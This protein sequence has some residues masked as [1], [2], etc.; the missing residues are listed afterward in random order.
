[1]LG[2]VVFPAD[3]EQEV[4]PDMPL[5][6]VSP[7][8]DL[9][10]Y[11]SG[12]VSFANFAGKC[13]DALSSPF[14]SASTIS[15]RVEPLDLSILE[16]LQRFDRSA[17]DPFA[18]LNPPETTGRNVTKEQR[19]I[20][21]TVGAKERIRED[22]YAEHLQM[23]LDLRLLLRRSQMISLTFDERVGY[24]CGEL[25]SSIVDEIH[26]ASLQPQWSSSYY[27]RYHAPPILF[28]SVLV[29][30]TI[31]IRTALPSSLQANLASYR[32]RFQQATT[33]IQDMANDFP[34]AWRLH[35]QLAEVIRLTKLT[36]PGCVPET[37]LS[38]DPVPPAASRDIEDLFSSEIQHLAREGGFTDTVAQ[39]GPDWLQSALNEFMNGSVDHG[40]PAQGVVDFSMESF[41]AGLEGSQSTE[42]PLWGDFYGL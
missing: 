26:Q 38:Q 9:Q 17:I 2:H 32:L 3:T 36:M 23:M 33:I 30:S 1:M 8:S 35:S 14:I 37:N 34:I 29:L 18:A 27:V 19:L 5:P 6:P 11:I 28:S 25:A 42:T 40:A 24:T 15:E 20:I 41:L 4:F 12:Y 16:W 22:P 7:N 31:I 10:P 21:R 39:A 13:W